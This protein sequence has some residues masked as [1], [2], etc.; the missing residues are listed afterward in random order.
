MPPPCKALLY[1]TFLL[2][3]VHGGP[4]GVSESSAALTIAVL[5]GV[6]LVGDFLL[7]PLL[8]RSAA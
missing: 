8:D 1:P 2:G 7:I 3:A 5:L 4:V 6:G